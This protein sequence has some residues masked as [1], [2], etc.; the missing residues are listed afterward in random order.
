M[1]LIYC[2]SNCLHKT[3]KHARKIYTNFNKLDKNVQLAILDHENINTPLI[4]NKKMINNCITE[5]VN[6][7][8][9]YKLGKN[10]LYEG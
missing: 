9:K 5:F 6:L 2:L 3:Y 4:N 10:I 1:K 8:D 7:C